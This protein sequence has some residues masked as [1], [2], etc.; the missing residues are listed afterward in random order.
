MA[1]ALILHNICCVSPYSPLLHSNSL[2]KSR[3]QSLLSDTQ[4]R[5]LKIRK[6]R[7]FT[8]VYAAQSNFLKAVQTVWK[9]AKDGIEVGTNMVPE[10][11]PRPVARISIT[12]V[13]LSVALYVLKSF[14]S[15]AFFV[16]ATM[17]L[18]YFIYIA[19]NKD[20]R[21]KGGAD[22]TPTE[23]DPVEEA[24]RIMEKYK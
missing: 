8:A 2:L 19:L 15:T 13:A 17:G 18:A 6:P 1:S 10:T 9:V 11:V 14:L 12:V 3:K 16:L 22:S 20:D 5:D 4:T 23:E 21:P 7:S 24:R